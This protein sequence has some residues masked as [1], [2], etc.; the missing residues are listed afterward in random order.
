[1][2]CRRIVFFVCFVSM[3]CGPAVEVSDDGT[4]DSTGELGE[5][6]QDG[7]VYSPCASVSQCTPLEFCVFPS[8]EQGFC[9]QACVAP[10]DPSQ[11]APAPGDG[12]EVSCMDIGIPDGRFVCA[13]DCGDGPCPS[14]MTC[15]GVE[16]PQG[17]RRI[18]F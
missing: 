16:T 10:D 15:E 17:A 4:G 7:G 8:G 11:C 12:A 6:P 14:P 5:Q 3:A 13:L 1:M 18:C 2:K 9:S